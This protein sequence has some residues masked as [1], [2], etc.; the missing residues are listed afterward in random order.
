MSSCIP[1]CSAV[2]RLSLVHASPS[3]DTTTHLLSCWKTALTRPG[4]IRAPASASRARSIPHHLPIPV[5]V[6]PPPPS[7]PCLYSR[8]AASRLWTESANFVFRSSFET[9]ACCVRRAR[10]V[11]SE[12]SGRCRCTPCPAL[13]PVF[14]RS[15]SLLLV[16]AWI[17][18]TKSEQDEQSVGYIVHDHRKRTRTRLTIC[19]PPGVQT[20]P[21]PAPTGRE[22]VAAYSYRRQVWHDSGRSRRPHRRLLHLAPARPDRAALLLRAVLCWRLFFAW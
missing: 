6:S 5:S 10:D 12:P 22:A 4:V 11:C 18:R 20:R 7:C 14:L 13:L 9:A 21:H 16:V 19:T 3:P 17:S 8:P 15:S 2:R 1:C